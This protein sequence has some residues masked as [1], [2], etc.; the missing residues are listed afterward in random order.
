MRPSIV[1]V[2]AF[3][4]HHHGR[5]SVLDVRCY[6]KTIKCAVA[7]CLFSQGNPGGNG[8]KMHSDNN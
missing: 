5:A 8:R 3:S 6:V 2:I 7:A 1:S 4:I